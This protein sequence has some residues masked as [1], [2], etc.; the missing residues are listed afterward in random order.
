MSPTQWDTP[1][2][3][4]QSDWEAALPNLVEAFFYPSL[5]GVA[6]CPVSSLGGGAPCGAPSFSAVTEQEEAQRR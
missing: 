1:V 5:R 4:R 2:A 6:G 3:I